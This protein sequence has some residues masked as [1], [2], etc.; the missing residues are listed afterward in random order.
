MQGLAIGALCA[1]TVTTPGR[2]SARTDVLPGVA[3]E[4]CVRDDRG[5]PTWTGA[6]VTFTDR[7]DNWTETRLDD[8]G[9][10]RVCLDHRPWSFYGASVPSQDPAFFFVPSRVAWQLTRLPGVR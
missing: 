8:V 6:R 4:V 7:D 10:A 5:R 9:C 1:L 3:R 2:R